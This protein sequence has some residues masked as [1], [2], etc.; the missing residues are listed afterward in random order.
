MK[1]PFLEDYDGKLTIGPGIELKT[2]KN[3]IQ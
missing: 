3:V 2:V 1:L